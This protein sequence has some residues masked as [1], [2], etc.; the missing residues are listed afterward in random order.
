MPHDNYTIYNEDQTFLVS[1]RKAADFLY[2]TCNGDFSEL[3]VSYAEQFNYEFSDGDISLLGK[4]RELKNTS[5]L[6][7]KEWVQVRENLLKQNPNNWSELDAILEINA[8]HF[9]EDGEQELQFSEEELDFSE[10]ESG[11]ME[12]FLGKVIASVYTSGVTGVTDAFGN[13]PSAKNN[14]LYNET[15]N[16]FS[17][18]FQDDNLDFEFSVFKSGTSGT[19]AIN[20]QP[21]PEKETSGE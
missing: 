21:L 20:Y 19:W 8:M 7:Y 6:S 13:K 17:G 10:L 16:S 9:V 1:A 15:N 11:K 12:K 18:K 4:L 5:E 2:E 14:Y 3:P